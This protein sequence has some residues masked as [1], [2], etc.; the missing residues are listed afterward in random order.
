MYT[1][2]RTVYTV[3][4][5]LYTVRGILY[6]VR[7]TLYTVRRTVYVGVKCVNYALYYVIPDI[8]TI[9]YCISISGITLS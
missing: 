5:K 4:R 3:R 9:L 7:H 2:R 6:T 1:V 8:D